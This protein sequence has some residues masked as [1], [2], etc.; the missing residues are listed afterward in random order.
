MSQHEK[1]IYE[2]NEGLTSAPTIDDA[3]DTP[4]NHSWELGE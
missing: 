4:Y 3:G 1:N 2:D